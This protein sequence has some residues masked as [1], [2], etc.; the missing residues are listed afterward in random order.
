MSQT[1]TNKAIAFLRHLFALYSVLDQDVSANSPQFVAEDF[2]VF[3]K[4]NGVKHLRC[5]PCHPASNGAVERVVR[6]FKQA[7]RACQQDGLTPQ[8]QLED[9]LFTYRSTPHATTNVAPC[10]LF[11]GR[12][13]HSRLDL[14]KLNL[15]HNVCE[16]QAEQ[17][18]QHDQHV[19]LRELT[20]G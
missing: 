10:D 3:M 18:Q 6:S 14:I 17:K 20:I 1:T 4:S 15:E 9:F 13:I 11:L 19:C 2:A 8:H 16:K 7:M 5:S 12:R